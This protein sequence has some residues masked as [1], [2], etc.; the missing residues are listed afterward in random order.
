MLRRSS[1]SQYVIVE[2]ASNTSTSP[3]AGAGGVVQTL[4]SLFRK[5]TRT[6]SV[7]DVTERSPIESSPN[8]MCFHC[9][10]FD[11][12]ALKFLGVLNQL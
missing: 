2:I 3:D 7:P 6:L 5:E 8:T 11:L 4:Q 9:D 12:F 1:P 10:L